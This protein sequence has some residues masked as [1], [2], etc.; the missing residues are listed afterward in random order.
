MFSGEIVKFSG[1]IVVCPIYYTILRLIF[2]VFAAKYNEFAFVTV[3]LCWGWFLTF[4]PLNITK[5][6]IL[7]NWSQFRRYFRQ[8][9]CRHGGHSERRPSVCPNRHQHHICRKHQV[10]GGH[11]E[12]GPGE[13][14]RQNKVCPRWWRQTPHIG[15]PTSFWWQHYP[16]HV[17]LSYE[18]VSKHIFI[19]FAAKFRTFF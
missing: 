16:P 2:N 7:I 19:K 5:S 17:L 1:E 18:N 12:M 10:G 13:Q 15:H 11:F 6:R 9:P 4:S 14:P 3:T 8:S